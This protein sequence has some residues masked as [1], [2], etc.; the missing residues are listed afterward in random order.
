MAEKT[1]VVN[2]ASCNVKKLDLKVGARRCLLLV[3]LQHELATD[4]Q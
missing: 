4:L 1:L 2:V 3:P